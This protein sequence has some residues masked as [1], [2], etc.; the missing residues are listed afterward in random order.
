MLVIQRT[1][2]DVML[3]T[4]HPSGRGPAPAN[5]RTSFGILPWPGRQPARSE[6]KGIVPN[7]RW[8][9]FPV[10]DAPRVRQ[11]AAHLVTRS[12][13]SGPAGVRLRTSRGQRTCTRPSSFR[14]RR[15]KAVPAGRRFWFW[16]AAVWLNTRR[17]FWG[18]GSSPQVER[19]KGPQ[20]QRTHW[21]HADPPSTDRGNLRGAACVPPCAARLVAAAGIEIALFA[22]RQVSRSISG[23]NEA[24]RLSCPGDPPRIARITRRGITRPGVS[25]DDHGSQRETGQ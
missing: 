6:S 14:A 7:G 18:C 9:L 21:R 15:R 22:E 12:W 4:R 2:G 20:P 23:N 17:L 11:A 16:C 13:E 10:P 3:L 1:K 5:A 25:L 24:S 8:R 19:G